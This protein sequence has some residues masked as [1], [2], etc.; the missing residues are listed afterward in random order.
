MLETIGY[1][2]YA[3]KRFFESASKTS[4]YSNTLFIITADH[5]AQA[6]SDFY[7]SDNGQYNIPMLWFRPNDTA[8]HSDKIFQHIDILP[9]LLDYLNIAEPCFSFGKSIYTSA[10]RYHIAYNNNYY[11]LTAGQWLILFNGTNFE[12][13]DLSADPLATKNIEQETLDNL[14]IQHC[15]N[16]LKAIIEQYNNRMIDNKLTIE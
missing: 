4:W 12:V 7:R 9:T 15:K 3:L 6:L 13:F 5:T 11:Q 14:D 16:L 2:D 1:A 8:F 10:E